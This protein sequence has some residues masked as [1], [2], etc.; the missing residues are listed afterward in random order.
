MKT[1]KTV[2]SFLKGIVRLH[3]IILLVLC[4][5]LSLTIATKQ[6]VAVKPSASVWA[7]EPKERAL[8]IGIE[9][10]KY[11]SLGVNDT[12]GCVEDVNTIKQLLLNQFKFKSESIHTLINEQATSSRI[13]QEI[14]DWLL[15]ETNPGDRVFFH[16]SG[17]GSQIKDDNNDEKDG[18]DDTIFTWDGNPENGD[19]EI[20]DDN[21]EKWILGLSGRRVVMIFDSCHSGTISR[22]TIGSRSIAPPD[23]F[24]GSRNIAGARTAK[25]EKFVGGVIGRG[26]AKVSNNN[27]EQTV[28]TV[29]IAA[30][31]E[32]QSAYPIKMGNKFIGAL[33]Y[34]FSSIIKNDINIKLGDL[35]SSLIAEVQKAS[36]SKQRP[37]VEYA[38]NNMTDLTQYPL[39][40]GWDKAVEVAFVNP[41]SSNRVTIKSKDGKSIYRSGEYVS[42]QVSTQKTGYLYLIVFSKE[43]N[44]NNSDKNEPNDIAI[45]LFP[46][47]DDSNNYLQ[48]E[49][50]ITIPQNSSYSFPVA[51]PYG[52]D[53]VVAIV[54][55]RPLDLKPEGRYS[56]NALFNLLNMKGLQ[57]SLMEGRSLANQSNTNIGYWQA[58]TTKFTTQMR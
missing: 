57:N 13:S 31:E 1:K 55:D 3:F 49:S 22:D 12:P 38:K 40:G 26:L 15:K 56:W 20:R 24:A 9:T 6:F 23:Q 43:E 30:A 18:Y 29:I 39:F 54:S 41:A 48:R 4:I 2:Y 33:T 47:S 16:Y 44:K 8:L 35:T 19:N 52:E 58:G 25:T 50:S 53:V 42:F 34:N 46:N 11:R 14:N 51:P 37:V 45:C 32:E 17:H 27:G 10:Y 5:G 36:S 28:G 7:Y 21:I